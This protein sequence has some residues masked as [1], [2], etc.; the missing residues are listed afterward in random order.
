MYIF[1][2]LSSPFGAMKMLQFSTSSWFLVVKWIDIVFWRSKLK[3]T[4]VP[5]FYNIT[6][7]NWK[8][9]QERLD[10]LRKTCRF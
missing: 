2:S 10:F 5:T 7:K 4:L 8:K 6:R 9:I 3:I 1:C